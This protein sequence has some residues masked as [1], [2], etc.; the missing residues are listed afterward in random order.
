VVFAIVELKTSEPLLELRLFIPA[1]TGAAYVALI[2]LCGF[3]P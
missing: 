2:A 1:F 3:S